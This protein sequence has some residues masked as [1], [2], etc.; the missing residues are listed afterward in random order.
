MGAKQSKRSVDISGKEAA[1]GVGDVAVAGGPG[2]L[3]PLADADTLKPHINGDAIIQTPGEVTEKEKQLENGTPENEKDATTEKEQIAQE[4]NKEPVTNGESEPKVEE[5]GDSTVAATPE[6]D[7]GK[8]PKKEKVKKKWSLRSISFSRKDKPKQEKKQ[9]EE[10]PKTNGEPEKV[11]E[12]ATEQT[13][14]VTESKSEVE[15]TTEN[16]DEK[17]PE[18]P[19]TEPLTNGSSAP[20]TPKE[21]TPIKEEAPVAVN[22]AIPEEPKIEAEPEQLPVNGLSLEEKKDLP[23][24]DDKKV[25]IPES[26]PE[27]PTSA[28][29]IVP[30]PE[31]SDKSEVCV[32]KTPLLESNPPP[33]PAN[34]PPSSVAS[35]AATTMAPHLTENTLIDNTTNLEMS[36][37]LTASPESTDNNIDNAPIVTQADSAKSE[38]VI[39]TEV[40]VE[41]PISIND[42]LKP[43]EHEEAIETDA[44]LSEASAVESSLTDAP[45]EPVK[46]EPSTPEIQGEFPIKEND[47]FDEEADKVVVV[48]GNAVEKNIDNQVEKD[49]DTVEENIIDNAIKTN[50]FGD[51]PVN[52]DFQGNECD[53]EFSGNDNDADLENVTKKTKDL[54]LTNGEKIEYNGNMEATDMD[55]EELSSSPVPPPEA[56]H[57]DSVASESFP[58]PP[59]E[60]RSESAATSPE[61]ED[62]AQEIVTVA[63]KMDVVVPE[64]ADVPSNDVITETSTEVATN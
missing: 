10:E 42:D 22:E 56:A 28:T 1:E 38:I 17:T 41:T 37:P 12:E 64:V 51:S 60:C 8:K 13:A 5:N 45:M 19:E 16:K 34:P 6:Q 61:P 2:K 43:C 39:N 20:E 62:A 52:K 48:A 50:G 15:I 40:S 44:C 21:A 31:I 58:L 54:S 35:F 18:T 26:K 29:E 32:D 23:A 57:E 4:E 27:E 55:A 25:E 47:K 3:E 46:Q 63:D 14:E 9:K 30:V 24:E 59:S 33:L 53:K 36:A 11:P 49:I 7:S